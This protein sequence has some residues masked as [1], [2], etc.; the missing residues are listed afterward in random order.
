MS[1]KVKNTDQLSVEELKALLEE[2][3]KAQRAL[4][5]KKRKQYETKRNKIMQVLCQTATL[6][7]KRLSTFKQK[8]FELLLSF[9][10]E[11]LDYGDLRGGKNNKGSF[12]LKDDKY[13]I[14]FS[15]QVIKRFDERA[16]MA[17]E[18]MKEF[19]KTFVK[20]RDTEVFEL[21]NS[22]LARNEKTG[23]FDINLIN[24]L[25]SLE[26]RFEDENWRKAIR[27][28]KEAYTPDSTAQY[29]RFYI[30]DENNKWQLI[31]LNFS[32]I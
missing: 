7:N 29:I 14:E 23:D 5:E 2:K 4:L 26:N 27:L 28:F 31:N 19:L 15:S 9:R 22:L 16:Q 21:V 12:M 20:K 6:N 1:E 25:Y 10:E 24:R 30:R 13:K 18:L 3:E 8:A 32:S 17:E 11:M